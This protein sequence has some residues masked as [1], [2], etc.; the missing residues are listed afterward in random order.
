MTQSERRIEV[1]YTIPGS[2]GG[3]K[4]TNFRWVICGLLL[5]AT[6]VN[7]MDRNVLGLLAPTLEKQIGWTESQYGYIVLAFQLAYAIGFIFVG[8]FLDTVGTKVGYAVAIL[9][10]SLA[11]MSHAYVAAWGWMGFMVARFALGL[12]ESGNFP[13]AIKTT[14]EWF[15][16]KERALAA[17]IFN[18][19]SN[20]GIIVAAL[21]V[22]VVTMKIGWKYA[23]FITGLLDLVW[24][25][26]W[27]LIYRKPEEHPS[28]SA[29]E[30][31][32]IQSDPADAP[33]RVAWGRLL[34]YRQTWAF[35]FGKF[36]TDPVWWF[37]LFWLPKFFSST[38]HVKL[39]GLVLPLVVIYVAADIGSIG[40]GWISSALMKRG[41]SVN[42]A[43]KTAMLICAACVAPMCFAVYMKQLWMTVGVV[44]LAAAAHQGWSANLFTLVSDTFPRRTVGSVVGLGGMFGAVG[45]MIAAYSIGHVLDAMHDNYV[46]LLTVAGFMYLIT[47]LGI[48]LLAPKLEPVALS[49][50]EEAS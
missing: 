28:V 12:G 21:L 26:L 7:Y 43:R 25:V 44:S 3:E 35:A 42:A 45:G 18:S 36:M 19:G 5:Y 1:G 33:V 9:V 16:K 49:G 37:F 13:A 32:Y 30:L 31:A 20:V 38:Y 6:T 48:H 22:P 46:P 17:G 14:A 23:F 4:K 39:T 40:G 29:G 47:L 50:P 27:G 8:K 10:W 41:W 15:P 11:S 24:L 2:G 34:G